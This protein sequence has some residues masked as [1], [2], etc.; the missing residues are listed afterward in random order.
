M[1]LVVAQ[2]DK[3][4]GELRG[5]NTKRGATW[6]FDSKWRLPTRLSTRSLEE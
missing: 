4:S 3:L 5:Q 6:E 2:G 1:S